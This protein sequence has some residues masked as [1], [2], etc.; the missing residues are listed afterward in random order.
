M[1][2]PEKGALQESKHKNQQVFS[3]P[4]P[5]DRQENDGRIR[6]L[7][8]DLV[9]L[10]E[11]EGG[12]DGTSEEVAAASHLLDRTTKNTTKYH[13]PSWIVWRGNDDWEPHTERAAG[14]GVQ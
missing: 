11:E 13:L 2:S 8:D 9:L 5:T 12:V 14:V 4:R 6:S 10:C 1:G 3:Q 7:G